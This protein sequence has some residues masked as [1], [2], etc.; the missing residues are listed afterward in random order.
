MAKSNASRM[1]V[2]KAYVEASRAASRLSLMGALGFGVALV[3]GVAL[4]RE[5]SL[6][7]VG[8]GLELILVTG[9][10]GG[11]IVFT[12]L[13]VRASRMANDCQSRLREMRQQPKRR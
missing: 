10:I 6:F 3:I 1:A 4:V 13:A 7:A 5:G 2:E 9:G 8:Y 11:G 12:A